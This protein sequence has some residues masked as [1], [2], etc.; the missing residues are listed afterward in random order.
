MLQ[1]V[2][3]SGKAHR[4]SLLWQLILHEF[5]LTK[6]NNNKNGITSVLVRDSPMSILSLDPKTLPISALGASFLW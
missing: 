6:S 3:Q 4:N 2:Q 1:R 5:H